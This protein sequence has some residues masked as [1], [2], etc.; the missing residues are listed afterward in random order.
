MRILISCLLLSFCS[1]VFAGEG[2]LQIYLFDGDSLPRVKKIYFKKNMSEV[3]EK[4]KVYMG[5]LDMTL[6]KGE[7]FL[8]TKKK[9]PFHRV[10]VVSDKKS[11]ISF[12]VSKEKPFIAKH[13]DFAEEINLSEDQLVT[14]KGKVKSNETGSFVNG[15]SVFLTGTRISS[16][17]DPSGAFEIKVPKGEKFNLSVIHE[18][19]RV[20][21]LENISH[22]ESKG[23]MDIKLLPSMGEMSEVVVLAPKTKGSIEDLL[24]ERR[25]IKAVSVSIG[26]EQFKKSGDSNAASAL[27]RVSGLSL[28]EG[29]YVYVRGLGER[30]SSTALNGSMLPSPNPLRRVVPLDLFPTSLIESILIQKSYSVDKPAQFSAGLVEIRTLSIPK[31]KS[32]FKMSLSTGASSEGIL[33]GETTGLSHAGGEK[34]IYG[35]DDGKRKLPTLISDAREQ[36][37]PLKLEDPWFDEPG[38]TE[39]ELLA[40]GKSFSDDYAVTDEK[41]GLNYGVSF[42]G[43]R[44]FKSGAQKAGFILKGL[45][46]NSNDH[47]VEDRNTYVIGNEEL[48][49]ARQDTIAETS[50]RYNTGA[51]LSTGF[52]FFKRHKI[53]VTGVGTRSTISSTEVKIRD[54]LANEEESFTT[55]RLRWEERELLNFQIKG[56][57]HLFENYKGP[58]LEWFMARSL[59]SN[60]RPDNKEYSYY[61]TT[62]QYVDRAFGNM[63]TFS[64]LKD[65]AEDRNIKL[66]GEVKVTPW[67]KIDA[68]AGVRRFAKKRRSEIQKFRFKLEGSREAFGLTDGIEDIINDANLDNGELVLKDATDGTDNYNASEKTNSLFASVGTNFL[69]SEKS[70]LGLSVG[71]RQEDHFQDIRTFN[72][73]DGAEDTDFS[74]IN[75][76][77]EFYSYGLVYKVNGKLSLRSGLSDTVARPDLQEFSSVIIYNDQENILEEGNPDLKIADVQNFD[78]RLDYYFNNREF[79]SFGVFR[80]DITNPIETVSVVGTDERRTYQN[81]DGALNDGLEV[82]F[83]KHLFKGIFLSG[84]YSYI[85]SEVRI[86]KDE[87]GASTSLNRP[88]QG[89]SP[90]LVNLGLE[91]SLKKIGFDTSVVYNVAGKRISQVGAF[92]SPDIYEEPFEQL[93]LTVRKKL[94][95]KLSISF[96]AQNLL[97]PFSERSQGGLPVRS[98]KYGRSYALS[99]SS[100]I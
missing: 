54:S 90:Y 39:A 95:K 74:E 57:H 98:F 41:I 35:Y 64:D 93:D 6:E 2:S 33:K 26:S 45:Y 84:N 100:S 69:F 77:K 31:K 49:L 56:E 61:L 94:T 65:V 82:E 52:D 12:D 58:K 66:S 83:R 46:S 8:S 28:V 37:L 4:H 62:G 88:L 53:D 7:Y 68:F 29:K 76:K 73:V 44:S 85:D 27:K 34:D 51:V 36:G 87:A 96:K 79:L 55:T 22:E 38:F 99:L 86:A 78:L 13:D 1:Q 50:H 75:Q 3:P 18:D 80:K 89:Q 72:I 9:G 59:S 17:T 47:D 21:S 11:Q 32:F 30:Y 81:I 10:I 91:Y 40:M 48:V 71:V 67:L 16:K 92:G 60:Y 43:G 63:T 70:S 42:E 97:D 23:V 15:A 24:K 20:A 5:M 25:K 14:F 19:Y